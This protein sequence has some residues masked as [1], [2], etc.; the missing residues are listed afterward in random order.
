MLYLFE[1]SKSKSG[2]PPVKHG[3]PLAYREVEKNRGKKSLRPAVELRQPVRDELHKMD[4]EYARMAIAVEKGRE[5]LSR[6]IIPP[7]PKAQQ[8]RQVNSPLKAQ[9]SILGN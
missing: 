3:D 6:V 8:Y 2:F 4:V 5:F 9:S 7:Q 1:R